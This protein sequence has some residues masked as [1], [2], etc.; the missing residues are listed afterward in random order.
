VDEALLRESS[1]T[2]SCTRRLPACSSF[3]R[4]AAVALGGMDA[5]RRGVVEA[6]LWRPGV[7]V[8]AALRRAGGGGV[9]AESQPRPARRGAAAAAWVGGAVATKGRGD[10]V[11]RKGRRR[12]GGEEG[13]SAGRWRRGVGAVGWPPTEAGGVRCPAASGWRLGVC[14][15]GVCVRV[16]YVMCG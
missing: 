1:A 7:A 15:R 11:A 6:T 9:A 13:P 4:A 10:G 16:C 12:H 14:V 5:A 8:E 2:A 3:L